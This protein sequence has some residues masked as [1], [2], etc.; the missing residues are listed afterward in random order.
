[1][2]LSAGSLQV[3]FWWPHCSWAIKHNANADLPRSLNGVGGT[4]PTPFVTTCPDGQKI[5]GLEVSG[6]CLEPQYQHKVA[7]TVLPCPFLKVMIS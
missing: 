1:M 4:G 7:A 3:L 2:P 6:A 5:L